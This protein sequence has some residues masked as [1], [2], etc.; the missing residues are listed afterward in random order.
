[1]AED[2]LLPE[3]APAMASN[4]IPFRRPRTVR[5]E[6]N[7]ELPDPLAMSPEEY[8]SAWLDFCC[9]AAEAQAYRDYVDARWFFLWRTDQAAAANLYPER[10]ESGDRAMAFINKLVALPVPLGKS[11]GMTRQH[12]GR[13]KQLIGRVWLKAEGPRYD[14]YRASI[15]KDEA[16]LEAGRA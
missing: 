15:A 3:S 7:F 13:K 11:R 1:M 9:A 8:E 6:V 4:V 10:G 2:T 16:L 5:I 14:A 12:I